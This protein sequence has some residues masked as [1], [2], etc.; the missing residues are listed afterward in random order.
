MTRL[1]YKQIRL[2]LPFMFLGKRSTVFLL[3]TAGD[4]QNIDMD[5]LFCTHLQCKKSVQ[6]CISLCIR[7]F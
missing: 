4:M 1:K 5:P 7:D 6:I 3:N 2:P